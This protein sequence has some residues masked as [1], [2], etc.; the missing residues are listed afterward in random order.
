MSS[1]EIGAALVTEARGTFLKVSLLLLLS[2]PAGTF[3]FGT[4]YVSRSEVRAETSAEND[5][6]VQREA[7]I[8]QALERSSFALDQVVKT[9]ER[10]EKRISD[11]NDKQ[12]TMNQELLVISSKVRK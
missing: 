3:W 9:Q 2:L 1:P 6:R 10:I 5:E 12:N 4:Q 11:V 7:R 8:V